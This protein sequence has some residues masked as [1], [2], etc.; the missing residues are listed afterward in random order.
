MSLQIKTPKKPK[1]PDVSLKQNN[2]EEKNMFG[3]SSIFGITQAIKVTFV[4]IV[5]S[6]DID[7]LV[8]CCLHFPFL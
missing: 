1:T 8:L 7:M 3:P 6:T 4:H 2:E 5:S